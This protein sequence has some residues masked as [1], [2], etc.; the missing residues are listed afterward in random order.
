[1]TTQELYSAYLSKKALVQ[2]LQSQQQDLSQR[3]YAA[4]QELVQLEENVRQA[5][6][7]ALLSSLGM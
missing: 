3:L 4:E 1:M 6:S 5:G 2:L 7:T